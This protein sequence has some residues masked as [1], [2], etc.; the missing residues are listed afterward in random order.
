MSIFSINYI[1]LYNLA[2]R[3]VPNNYIALGVFTFAESW[4]VSTFVGLAN[5][6]FSNGGQLVLIAAILTLGITLS[7]TYYA[8]TTKSDF[9]LQG[10]AL[11]IF[12]AVILLVGIINFFVASKLL[13]I[14]YVSA[15]AILFG[16]YLIYDTQLIVGGK[17][18]ELDVDDYIIGA[19]IIYIDII[20]IFLQI[21]QLLLELFGKKD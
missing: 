9:T 10:G 14:L 17:S 4:M 20:Q 1:D 2:A 13:H 12:G 11:F 16:F 8:F 15:L 6:Q 21:L 3:K 19:L 18:H 5:L 7:L